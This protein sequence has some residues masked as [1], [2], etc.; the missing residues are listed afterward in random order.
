MRKPTVMIMDDDE[1]I[2]TLFAI[3]LKKLGYNTVSAS[4]GEKAVTLYRQSLQSDHPIDV[5]ILDLTIPGGMDGQQTAQQLLAIDAHAK[6]IV[7]S[8]NSFSPVM[9]DCQAY[10]FRGAIEK[11][12]DRKKM[13]QLL[14]QVLS[15]N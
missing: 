8:G 10:G 15:S 2:R 7:S 12:F 14:T 1:N 3:N 11:T 6:L 5:C 4:S 13:Q 9:T